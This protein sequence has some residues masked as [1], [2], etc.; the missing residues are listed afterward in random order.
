MT[1]Y[2]GIDPTASSLHVGH[3]LPFLALF[4]LTLSGHNA[5]A[6]VGGS[7]ASVGD[8]TGRLV[9]RAHQAKEQRESNARSM[10]AQLSML[11]ERFVALAE[12]HGFSRQDMGT[13]SVL[14]NSQWLNKVSIMDFLSILGSKLRM[15]ALLSR[16]T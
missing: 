2:V 16:D 15:G 5:V 8:P 13:I 7:T 12:K 9:S 14:D 10:K 11:S 4:W 1:A 6:L 3:L